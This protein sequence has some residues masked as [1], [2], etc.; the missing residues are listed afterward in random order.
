MLGLELLSSLQ[1]SPRVEFEADTIRVKVKYRLKPLRQLDCA[2]TSLLTRDSCSKTFFFSKLFQARV[3]LG[4]TPVI[5]SCDR[6]Y[7]IPNCQLG[8]GQIPADKICILPL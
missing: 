5:F 3:P 2:G 1:Y 7:R 8:F 4:T 6:Q